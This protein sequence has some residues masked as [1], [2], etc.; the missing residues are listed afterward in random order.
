MKCALVENFR[1]R[2]SS[3][4]QTLAYPTAIAPADMMAK[5]PYVDYQSLLSP[6]SGYAKEASK[7][8]LWV[9]KMQAGTGSSLTRSTYLSHVRGTALLDTHVG[10]K[11]TDLY[12]SVPGQG[13]RPI[14]EIQILQQLLEDKSGV[15]GDVI[16]H[17][18]VSNETIDS[19]NAIWKTPSL[20]NTK[21]TYA[22]STGEGTVRRF[23]QQQ[24]PTINE[25]GKVTYGRTAPSG[26]WIFAIDALRSAIHETELPK[27]NG[28]TLISVIG[29]GEDLSSTPDAAMVGW[30]AKEKIPIVMVTTE[31]TPNDLKGG[32]IALVKETTGETF[33]SII[34]Q[35]QAKEA[36][37]LDLFEKLGLQ[38]KN[39]NQIAFFNTNMALFNYE[40]LVPKLKGLVSEIGEKEF[41][42]I[43][44]PDLILNWKEQKDADSIVRK[45]LQIEGAMGS[46]LLNLDRFW[47][48]KYGE[49]LVHFINVG[50]THRTRFFSPIK[51]AFDY[52]MQFHSDA[53]HLD[54]SQM[55]LIKNG[56][57]RLPSVN[58][59][60]K[61]YTDVKNVLTAFKGASVV[62]L[63]SLTVEGQVMMPSLRLKGRVEVINR[64]G[65]MVDL[66]KLLGSSAS[67]NNQRVEIEADG[68]LK[69]TAL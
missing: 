12:A 66:T 55:R 36:G 41:L 35:A 5:L 60:D 50:E 2:S 21:Q 49:P 17:D 67:L 30:M 1:T 26:H 48:A 57:G 69:V 13:L 28:R 52:F 32:Q 39:D 45:Y 40:V 27:T 68:S 42:R 16:F 33:V 11:G 23:V 38:V 62:E 22:Q 29:N 64:A 43:L 61:F 7:V 63:T 59:K 44:A 8:A 20:L 54:A 56:H 14:A 18:L 47:R 25:A 24:V 34:E 19:M 46:T 37:Q 10:A 9:K 58:L 6:A 15:F 65:A 31:K 53:F 4:T 51:T 3:Q